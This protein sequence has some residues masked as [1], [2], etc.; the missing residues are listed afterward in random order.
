MTGTVT[1]SQGGAIT[2]ATVTVTPSGAAALP[3]VQT[4]GDGSYTVDAV[5]T[6]DGSVTVTTVPVNC[7]P[8]STIQ[9]TGLKNGGHH[10]ANFVIGCN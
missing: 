3:T 9:Y 1:S 5:P 2:G 8:S 7:Q 4:A 6:G 10:I